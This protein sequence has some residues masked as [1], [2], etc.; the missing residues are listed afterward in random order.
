[1]S[2]NSGNSSTGMGQADVLLI[3]F[4]VLKLCGVIDWSWWWV[5]SPLWISLAIV[6]LIQGCYSLWG[7][8]D[9]L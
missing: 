4:I 5:L 8:G 7:D 2:K 9:D 6:I 3:V 1:M